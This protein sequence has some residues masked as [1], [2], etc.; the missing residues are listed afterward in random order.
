MIMRKTGIWR[1]DAMLSGITRLVLETGTITSKS[2]SSNPVVQYLSLTSVTAVGPVPS[3][4]EG[5]LYAL[6]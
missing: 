3:L 5:P 4:L 6:L 2:K 1:T